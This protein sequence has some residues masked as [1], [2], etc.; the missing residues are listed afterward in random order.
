MTKKK[1][2]EPHALPEDAQML[3]NL[4]EK[5][6]EQLARRIA[7]DA[8]LGDFLKMVEMR[9]KLTPGEAEQKKFWQMLDRIRLKT[10]AEM[11]AVRQLSAKPSKA[12]VTRKGKKKS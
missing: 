12:T 6:Y 8:K 2:K 4:I 7:K 10:D 9:A 5:C 11:N 1:L 3:D